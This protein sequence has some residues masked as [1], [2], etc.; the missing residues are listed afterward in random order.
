MV[1]VNHLVALGLRHPW[2]TVVQ[3]AW[4]KY[5][6]P[7][8]P[9]VV[10]LDVIERNLDKQSG[11]LKVRRLMATEWGIPNWIVKFIGMTDTCYVDERIEVDPHRKKMTLLSRN[12]TY[13]N[14]LTMSETLVYSQDPKDPSRTLLVQDTSVNVHGIPM[15]SYIE[16]LVEGSCTNNSQKGRQ[17]MEW[18]IGVFVVCSG[19]PGHGVV[20]S[21]FVVCSGSP[22]HGVGHQCGRQA[23]EWVI[24]VFVACSGS[25]G[26]GVGHQC[27]RQAMEWVISKIKAEAQDLT[28][29]A[30]TEM[31]NL[32]KLST[33]T[34]SSF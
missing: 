24:S 4:R 14:F 10:A 28:R 29:A 11:A 15:T 2:E 13:C 3:A 18:V 9:S 20:I 32:K 6:N 30:N 26:H 5:P 34:K 31:D 16:S 27:G 1:H 25:P 21:V 17:A 33:P 7:L 23:T 8:N 19:S 22:G 12:L